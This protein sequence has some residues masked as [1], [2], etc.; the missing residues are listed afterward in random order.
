M[1]A[2]K[3]RRQRWQPLHLVVAVWLLAMG[4]LVVRHEGGVAAT[5]RAAERTVRRY[6]GHEDG[7]AILAA[8][9]EA[10][11]V[12]TAAAAPAAPCAATEASAAALRQKALGLE[13]QLRDAGA[14][15]AHERERGKAA[16]AELEA[17]RAA[18]APR[19]AAAR[20]PAPPR[21]P[22][23]NPPVDS[24]AD[25]LEGSRGFRGM[26]YW[27]RDPEP[28]V[29]PYA[30]YGPSAKYVTF[31]PDNGGWNNIRMAFET[32]AVFAH[33]TGRTLVMPPAQRLYLLKV[34]HE[35]NRRAH[36]GVDAFLNFDALGTLPGLFSTRSV[37]RMDTIAAGLA[38]D[39]ADEDARHF[40]SMIVRVK[41][42]ITFYQLLAAVP[43]VFG[44]SLEVPEAYAQ[45][46]DVS[47]AVASLFFARILPTRCLTS[48]SSA[49]YYEQGLAATALAPFAFAL[50]TYLGWAAKKTLRPDGGDRRRW[51]LAFQMFL[52]FLHLILP[53]LC[54]TAVQSLVCDSYDEGARGRSRYLR[55]SPTISCDGARWRGRV[56]VIGGLMVA[57]YPAGIP[58]TFAVLLWRCRHDLNPESRVSIDGSESLDET[59]L[60]AIK[61]ALPFQM[62]LI[63]ERSKICETSDEIR[64]LLPATPRSGDAVANSD[65]TRDIQSFHFLWC[66]YEPRVFM[67]EIVEVA[68]R[69]FFT[70]LIAIVDPGG[71]FQLVVALAVSVVFTALYVKYEPFVYDADDAIAQVASWS[72]NLTLLIALCLRAEIVFHR[73]TDLTIVLLC[74][75]ALAPV[76]TVCWVLR[77][78]PGTF[79]SP[80]CFLTAAQRKSLAKRETELLSRAKARLRGE[81]VATAVPPPPSPSPPPPSPPRV[82]SPPSPLS[83]PPPPATSP[84][85]EQSL[86]LRILG[87][88]AA[89]TS[90]SPRE[91]SS[92]DLLF[93]TAPASATSEPP[94]A[95]EAAESGVAACVRDSATGP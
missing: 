86:G 52:L 32:V 5:E 43:Y 29:S 11:A 66:D 85:P 56:R 39:G 22:P 58:L 46:Q 90:G 8:Q 34:Q 69:V 15:L 26:R 75:A 41:A 83:P 44:E 84:E 2:S 89:R 68:R 57:L 64:G 59:A 82:A 55:I 12:A 62:A 31:E 93:C 6:V 10:V 35:G 61:R 16:R 67:W 95:A 81:T 9:A 14:A 74:A 92:L 20:R 65:F 27:A 1:G 7:A 73:R 87:E 54:S 88:L 60:L 53:L 91:A 71:R 94:D 78:V 40:G 21:T 13:A 47:G 19:P 70:A 18:A 77:R 36:H 51:Y 80:T 30:D 28:R 24:C 3:Q 42:L 79:L 63:E 49:A 4:S 50:I 37:A 76:L 25:V 23:Q 33:A 72:V 38:D 48:V 45:F 17:L